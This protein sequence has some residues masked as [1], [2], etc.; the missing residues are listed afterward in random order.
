[1]LSRSP[2]L[3]VSPSPPLLFSP[4]HTPP[5]AL[6]SPS[7]HDALPISVD[8]SSHCLIPIYWDTSDERILSVSPTGNITGKEIGKAIMTAT[9]RSEEHTSELQSRFD[10]VCRLLLQKQNTMQP[11]QQS[12]QGETRT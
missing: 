7:L 3:P 11:E 9:M 8:L 2:P 1:R 10:L 4:P 5:S 12:A 6:H